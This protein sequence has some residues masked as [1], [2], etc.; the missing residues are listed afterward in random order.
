MKILHLL[1]F[2]I[3]A[4]PAGEAEAA[5]D[6]RRSLAQA[7]TNHTPVIVVFGANW[8]GDCQM[9]NTAMKTGASAS[10]LAHDFKIVKVSVGTPVNGHLSQNVDIARSYGLSLEKGI[11]A[12]V[13]LSP[14]NAVLYA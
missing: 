1:C 2:M 6:I 13:I 7:A 11:P 12:V 9:L 10:L 3:L 14:D 4:V 5:Q 8:C